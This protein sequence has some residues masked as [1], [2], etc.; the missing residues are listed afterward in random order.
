M[1]SMSGVIVRQM[2]FGLVV[3]VLSLALLGL[4]QRAGYAG[5]RRRRAGA[6]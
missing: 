3:F 1:R 6:A 5:A 2:L 4:V